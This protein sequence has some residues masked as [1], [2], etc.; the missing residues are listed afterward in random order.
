MRRVPNARTPANKTNPDAGSGTAVTGADPPEP[1]GVNG[2]ADGSA[3]GDAA[4]TASTKEKLG[5]NVPPFNQR[6][7]RL[8]RAADTP[9]VAEPAHAKP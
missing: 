1:D 7:V 9:S 5:S 2:A 3:F 8:V 6:A 4:V